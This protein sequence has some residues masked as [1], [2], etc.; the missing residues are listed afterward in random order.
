MHYRYLQECSKLVWR[1]QRLKQLASQGVSLKRRLLVLRELI[2]R[3][4]SL[5]RSIGA[6]PM[7]DQ[8][9]QMAEAVVTDE[10]EAAR[11]AEENRLAK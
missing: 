5:G 10:A 6:A 11:K 1:L 8:V 4:V 7:G 2:S 9:Q 3:Q